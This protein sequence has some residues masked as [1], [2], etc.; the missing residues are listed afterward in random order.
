MVGPV[1]RKTLLVHAALR[2]RVPSLQG[3][4]KLRAM[5]ALITGCG[6]QDG[7]YLSKYLLDLGYQVFGGYRRSTHGV[8]P[9]G[10]DPV[11]VELTE[12][13]AIRRAIERV[14]PDEI[15]NLGAQTHVGESF[16]CPL[17][18]GEVN[19]L[20]VGRI[21]ECIRGSKIRL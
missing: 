2:I 4:G 15:Y 16:N 1:R 19:H 7:H 13:E 8:V 5:R 11:P 6:G 14:R 17:F 18:T 20:G 3:N 9:E 21:L 12:Y 10:V